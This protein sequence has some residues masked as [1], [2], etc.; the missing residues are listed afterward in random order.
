MPAVK[1]GWNVQIFPILSEWRQKHKLCRPAM[2]WTAFNRIINTVT[3][4]KVIV[5]KTYQL[6]ALQRLLELSQCMP[7]GKPWIQEN[8]LE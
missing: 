6:I 1:Y 8:L 7:V 3:D 2:E 4:K 5:C